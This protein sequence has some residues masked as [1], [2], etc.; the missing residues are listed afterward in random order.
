MCV[1]AALSLNLP[2]VPELITLQRLW[3]Y[4]SSAEINVK[5]LWAQTVI[6][7]DEWICIVRGERKG[8]HSFQARG[9][10]GGTQSENKYTV[11]DMPK[12]F[13]R[14]QRMWVDAPKE[15]SEAVWKCL[16]IK[17]VSHYLHK[18]RS[19]GTPSHHALREFNYSIEWRLEMLVG[20][21]GLKDYRF[22]P[23][24]VSL[25]KWAVMRHFESRCTRTLDQNRRVCNLIPTRPPCWVWFGL[26]L[27]WSTLPPVVS[28][29]CFDHPAVINQLVLRLL[30]IRLHWV[31]R[32]TYQE[33]AFLG[34]F[35][36]G[37]ILSYAI[38]HNTLYFGGV[39]AQFDPQQICRHGQYFN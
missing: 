12:F 15:F 33:G 18:L 6:E 29:M 25:S 35:S 14:S 1:P 7:T 20:T 34:L 5:S 28:R 26:Y 21:R 22:A 10:G 13:N 38:D 31:P 24:C 9:V 8:R 3:E 19:Q 2:P 32:E 16:I 17:H 4:L 39:S 11:T 30:L 36:T 37:I 27:P 23:F